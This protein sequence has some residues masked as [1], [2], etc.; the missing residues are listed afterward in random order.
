MGCALPANICVLTDKCHIR[1]VWEL[2][3]TLFWDVAYRSTPNFSTLLSGLVGPAP[4]WNPGV[5]VAVP[6]SGL[7]PSPGPSEFQA[8]ANRARHTR[9]K[10]KFR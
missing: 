6:D 9:K 2:T 10:T 1:G 7:R 5:R 8:E 3:T 4:G